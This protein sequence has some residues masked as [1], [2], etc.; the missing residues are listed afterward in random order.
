MK[1]FI[2]NNKYIIGLTLLVLLS[3]WQLSFFV[4]ISKWDNIDAYL[5]YRYIVSDYLWNGKFPLWNPFLNLGTPTYS[6]LQSGT[7]YPIT[8]IIML[9]GK[10]TIGALTVE[11]LS[12]YI[13]AAFGFYKLSIFVYNNQKVAFLLGLSYSLS[14]FMVGSSQ[15]LPFLIG[16][17]WLPWIIYALLAF[18]QTLKYTYAL[19]TAL[20]IAVCTSGASPP[21]IIILIYAFVA[22]FG[23]HLWKHRKFKKYILTILYGGCLIV[24]VSILLLLPYINSFMEFLPYFNRIDRLPIEKLSYNNFTFYEYISFVFPFSVLSVSDL[25]THT[26]VTLRSSYFGIIGFVFLIVSLFTVRNRYFIPLLISAILSLFLAAGAATPFYKL[27][28]EIPGFAMFKHSSFFK[29][30]FIFSGLLLAGFAI[31]GII[32]NKKSIKTAN[33]IWLWLI[34]FVFILTVTAFLYLPSGEVSDVL[35][36]I[37]NSEEGFSES[38]ASHFFVNGIILLI[39]LSLGRLIAKKKNIFTG[40]LIVLI[41][42]LL[43]QTQLSAPKTIFNKIEYE[44]VSSFFNELPDEINQQTALIP[45]KDVKKKQPLKKLD[46]FWRNLPTL[47]KTISHK[48]YNPMRFK[49]FEKGKNNGAL[50]KAIENPILYFKNNEETVVN[51]A[52]IGYNEFKAEVS[53]TSSQTQKFLLNQNYHAQWKCYY[54]GNELLVIKANDM[55][56]EVEIPATSKGELQFIFKSPRT[57]YVFIISLLTYLLVTIYLIKAFYFKKSVRVE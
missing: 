2:L 34:G 32:E 15:I 11:I 5:P 52:F 46:G 13:I 51:S 21:F 16:I 53:N 38:L 7:W 54:N 40:L 17:A 19:L 12:C 4:Y 6:D 36:R 28:Y 56:M 33:F 31:K 49:T 24:G 18:L 50:E 44:K 22:F 20:F 42:D 14:G 41:F 45:I 8:W 37:I 25:F 23:Y 55:I 3:L 27:V 26:D 35:R 30:Y 43:I 57:G 10:Y 47:N 39:L 9:F 48:G 1:N 29:V